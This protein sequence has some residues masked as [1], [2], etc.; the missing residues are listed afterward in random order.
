MRKENIIIN[1]NKGGTIMNRVLS[2]KELQNMKYHLNMM[3]MV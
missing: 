3:M 2:K 1:A